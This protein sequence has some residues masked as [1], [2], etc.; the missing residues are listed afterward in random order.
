MANRKKPKRK[1]KTPRHVE[2]DVEL[3]VVWSSFSLSVSSELSDSSS[4]FSKEMGAAGI[5]LLGRE[6]SSILYE[7]TRGRV[8]LSQEIYI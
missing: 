1:G 8:E 2:E 7:V 4:M 5:E 6:P 3:F